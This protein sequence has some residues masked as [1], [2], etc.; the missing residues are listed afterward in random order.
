MS[1]AVVS[2]T[3]FKAKCLA[4]LDEIEQRG[5]TITITRRG[6]PAAVLGPPKKRRWKSPK[7]SRKTRDHRDIVNT[8]DLWKP[9]RQE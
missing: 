2:L 5:E 6:R 1:T 8:P 9:V 3:E 4:L 7:N